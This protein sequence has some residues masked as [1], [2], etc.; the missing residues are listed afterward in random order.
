MALNVSLVLLIYFYLW[1]FISRKSVDGD[2][3]NAASSSAD[4][5]SPAVSPKTRKRQEVERA[6]TALPVFVHSCSVAGGSG[7]VDDTKAAMECAICIAEFVD[8]AEG[9][10]LPR[11]GQRFD[12]LCVDVWF[13]FHTT[14]QLYRA[15]ILSAAAEPKS[16]IWDTNTDEDIDCSV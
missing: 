8:G 11:C 4:E 3:D 12:F 10:L 13:H 9:R 2:G 6:I 1:R 15:S 5:P 7:A 16:K 14:C